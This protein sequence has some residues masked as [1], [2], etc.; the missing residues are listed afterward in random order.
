MNEQVFNGTFWLSLAG[1]VAGIIG[2]VI[3]VVN[4]SKCKTVN[5]C[6][7][8]FSCIRDTEAEI[9]IEKERIEH[10]IPENK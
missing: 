1:V 2:V 8:L 6:G 9:E 5:C 4:K 10:N 7:G 3:G